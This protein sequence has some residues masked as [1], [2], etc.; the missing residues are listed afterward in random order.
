MDGVNAFILLGT[1][2]K[3]RD[4]KHEKKSIHK[5]LSLDF[6]ETMIGVQAIVLGTSSKRR[7]KRHETS[8]YLYINVYL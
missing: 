6:T 7:D 3:R 8:T 4:K 2:S 5:C 1:R